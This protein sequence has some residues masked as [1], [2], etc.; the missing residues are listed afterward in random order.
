MDTSTRALSGGSDK[1]LAHSTLALIVVE[2][3][4]LWVINVA[5][6]DN[7]RKQRRSR[8]VMIEYQN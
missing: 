1:L 2:K 7:G 6:P 5:V 3:K 8:S 4:K